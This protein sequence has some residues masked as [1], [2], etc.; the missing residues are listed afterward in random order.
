LRLEDGLGPNRPATCPP[1]FYD[2]V[3]APCGAVDPAARPTFAALAELL[4]AWPAFEPRSLVP[5]PGPGGPGIHGGG[6]WLPTAG[7][8][9]GTGTGTLSD[10]AGSAF[11]CPVV[12]W[13]LPPAPARRGSAGLAL[14][15]PAT[16][17]EHGG[18]YST[19]SGDATLPSPYEAPDGSASGPFYSPFRAGPP[20]VVPLVDKVVSGGPAGAGGVA[21]PCPLLAE[22]PANGA[23]MVTG[24][25][26]M[27]IV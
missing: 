14:H 4:R 13:S 6:E 12:R 25:V 10:G 7:A 17:S 21:G 27:S 3:L 15:G 1:A 16:L 18:F 26:T 22:K 23:M 9:T 19:L 11:V 20:P 5:Q 24:S 8:S 2:H